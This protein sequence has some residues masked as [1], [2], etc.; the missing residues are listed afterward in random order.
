MARIE[1]KRENR[2]KDAIRAY[3]VE[4]DGNVIG[5]INKGESTG[6]DIPAGKHRLKLKIDWCGSPY[7]DF[8]IQTGQILRFECGNN[9]PPFLVFVYITFLRNKYLWLNQVG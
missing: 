2:F 7:V 6:F 1:L 3:Q 5:K 9:V 4:L 8:E